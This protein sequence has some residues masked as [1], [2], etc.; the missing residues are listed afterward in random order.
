MAYPD[1]VQCATHAAL[2]DVL[3]NAALGDHA[4]AH[5]IHLAQQL[6]LE[7]VS[8]GLAR[9]ASHESRDRA[10]EP[11]AFPPSRVFAC[12]VQG[13]LKRAS[14]G[15]AHPVRR[16]EA[17][18]PVILASSKELKVLLVQLSSQRPLVWEE[19]GDPTLVLS[20]FGYQLRRLDQLYLLIL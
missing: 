13:H 10:I 7:D 18:L 16:H 4:S 9:V 5:V 14:V 15:L 1:R 6:E 8:G 19:L 12:Q 11:S 3:T 2:A 20:A 17:A